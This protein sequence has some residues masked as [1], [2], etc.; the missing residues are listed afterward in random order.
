M[1]S[2]PAARPGELRKEG[3]FAARGRPA[4]A[5]FSESSRPALLEAV[6]AVDGPRRVRLEGDLRRFA[7]IRARRREQRARPAVEP[8]PSPAS[9]FVH[10]AYYLSRPFPDGMPRQRAP[11]R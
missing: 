11:G 7:A 9:L 10:F 3:S 1:S 5:S 4:L 6:A 8:A 2:A